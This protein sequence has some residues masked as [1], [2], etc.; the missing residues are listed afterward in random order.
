MQSFGLI[1]YNRPLLY[2]FDQQFENVALFKVL[3]ILIL[4][5]EVNTTHMIFIN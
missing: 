3:Y 5:A 2:K 1:L 4:F